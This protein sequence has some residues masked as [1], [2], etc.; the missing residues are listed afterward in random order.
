MDTRKSMICQNCKYFAEFSK[1][2][3]RE[4]EFTKYSGVCC[5]RNEGRLAVHM[6]MESGY[7]GCSEWEEKTYGR[8]VL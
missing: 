7:T 6:I 5:K 3:I 2:Y 4:G 1:P 8:S